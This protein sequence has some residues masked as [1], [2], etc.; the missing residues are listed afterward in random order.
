MNELRVQLAIFYK[1]IQRLHQLLGNN[2]IDKVNIPKDAPK[3]IAAKV[4][5]FNSQLS[6]LQQENSQ[7]RRENERLS[8]SIRPAMRFDAEADANPDEMKDDIDEV[9]RLKDHIR[10]LEQVRSS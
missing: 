3:S 5:R 8:K 7:L 10:E 6:K 1:E 9:K 4:A 2:S